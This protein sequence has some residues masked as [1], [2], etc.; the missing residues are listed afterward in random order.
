MRPLISE[1][2]LFSAGAIALGLLDLDCKSK[3][4][5]E[6]APASS[7]SVAA[8]PVAPSKLEGLTRADF[9]RGAIE[10]NQPFFWREDANG[11][12]ALEPD[13]FVVV[14]NDKGKTR[15]DFLSGE[16]EF[17]VGF[18]DV[19]NAILHPSAPANLPPDEKKRRE[20]VRLELAQGRP[21]LVDS[22]FSSA[23]AEKGLVVH[24]M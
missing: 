23:G 12:G 24:L 13:E 5:A 20:A 1:V 3:T 9:N 6:P 2:I 16:H 8:P 15:P 4:G 18:A 22:D 7:A 14:F 10:Q 21:T 19:Y 17:T 11:D